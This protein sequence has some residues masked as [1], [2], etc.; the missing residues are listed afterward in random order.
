M[1]SLTHR[2]IKCERG[3][4]G[5]NGSTGGDYGFKANVMAKKERMGPAQQHRPDSNSNDKKE[6]I[7]GTA[8]EV[9]LKKWLPPHG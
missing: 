9:N 5:A 2:G 8:Q 1:R 6:G 7:D 4:K 3:K